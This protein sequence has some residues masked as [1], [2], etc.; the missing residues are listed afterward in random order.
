MTTIHAMPENARSGIP[1][2]V[3]AHA[4]VRMQQRAIP[5]GV[6]RCLLRLGRRQHDGHGA[7][8]VYFDHRAWRRANRA[9]FAQRVR[10]FDRYRSAYAVVSVEDGTI[11]TVGRR[12]KRIHR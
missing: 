4:S 9:G 12:H 6:L 5:P 8:I 11:V 1:A 7:Q 3:S 10:N 2:A